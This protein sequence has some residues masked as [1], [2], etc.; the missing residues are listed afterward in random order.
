[1][2][3]SSASKVFSLLRELISFYWQSH[4][5]GKAEERLSLVP[6]YLNLLAGLGYELQFLRESCNRELGGHNILLRVGALGHEI[7]DRLAHGFGS[8][9]HAEMQIATV[10]MKLESSEMKR[11]AVNNP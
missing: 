8:L 1:M 11:Q 7:Q 6:A 4:E 9:R 3:Q 2:I 5:L 10:A